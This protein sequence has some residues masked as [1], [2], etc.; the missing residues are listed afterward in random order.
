M[1]T[2]RIDI[3]YRPLRIGWAI[4][5][6]D[7]AAFRQAV[8]L[9][10]TMWGGRYNPIMVVD[11]EEESGRL[12]DLFR[13]DLII[14][15]SDSGAVKEFPKRFPYLISPFFPDSL[16]I[17]GTRQRKHSQTLDIHNM[18]VHLRNTPNWKAIKDKG[19]RVYIW[20]PD[21]PLADVFLVQFG[22]YPSADEIG[23]DYRD[24]LFQ[25]S[26][27]REYSIDHASAISVDALEHP[28]ISYLSRHGLERH[29]SVEAGWDSPGFFVGDA[30][31]VDDLVCHWNLRASDI[32]LWFVDP[33]HLDRYTDIIPA[34]EQKMR[35]AVA[36]RREW[37]QD[38]AVWSRRENIDEA[39]KPFGALKLLGCPISIHSWNGRNVRPPM[40][41]L[42]T[43]SVLGVM[44][45]E[46]GKTKVSFALS[47]KPF[48][49]DLWFHRQHLL[50]S[51]SFIGG[52]Y[53][54]E[55][56]TLNP[57][58]LPELNEFYARTM[59]FHYNKLRI[60]PRRVGLVMNASDHDSFL[61]ALPVSELME[62][63]FG[64]AGYN[65]KLSPGGLVAR[66]LIARLDGIQGGRVF[67]IPGVRRLL[68]THGPR[69]S[70]TKRAALQ[71]I[72]SKDPE[73]PE[74][75]FSDHEDL[76]IEQ[77]QI[78]TK[79]QPSE[80]FAYLVEK[81]LFRIGA[82]MTCPNCRMK[83][84]TPLDSLKQRVICELCGQEHDATR[85]LVNSEWQY[86]RS[87]VL[88]AEKNA[89]GAVPVALILQQLAVNLPAVFHDDVYSPSLELKPKKGVDLPQCEVDFVWVIPRQYP[90]KTVIILGECKDQ[91]PTKLVE[92]EKDVENLRRVAD[93]LP[94]KRFKTFVLLSK[95]APFTPDEIE[96]ARGLNDKY[97]SR[98][99][100]LT[101]REL[102]PY[103]IFERT[104]AE[105]D[106]KG[107]GGTPED[108]ALATVE[109][110]FKE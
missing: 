56:Y 67:K 4:R 16:F 23:I 102:E 6:G 45:R 3:C 35:E 49:G 31:N 64:M 22:V 86:R 9:S 28:T 68:R 73:N 95:L 100:L 91:G 63:I 5:A 30:T 71:L 94:R 106:I 41:H 70:F 92:F 88:G 32:P 18:L 96:R 10:Y 81:G 58:Y 103:H 2:I 50:A 59:H 74:A 93:A 66:Q 24:M 97:R 110:F 85:Q 25:A 72:G 13:V 15:I 57:P 46:N 75:K 80:V 53:G 47:E 109:M 12:V 69:S 20:Q 48:C 27:A 90:R 42:G 79:L 1:D 89:Q 19:L 7:L 108:L 84:W 101:A 99:I 34:W 55:H 52:L 60:E 61:Y 17:S 82:D 105:F 38:V 98:A 51:I 26:E 37:R 107:L 77:R 36:Y 33:K 43:V 83:S 62:R 65:A 21:D 44:S 76:Y 104:K 8:Q 39:R 87:G 78:G 29:Y 11:H 14:P 54:D 40:M